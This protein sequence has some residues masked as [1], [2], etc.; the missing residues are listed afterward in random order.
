[1][2]GASDRLDLLL[3]EAGAALDESSRTV[4]KAA[5]LTVAAQTLRTRLKNRRGLFAAREG[6]ARTLENMAQIRMRFR[7]AA[8]RRKRRLRGR[9]FL[10]YLRRIWRAV[11]YWLL[12][13]LLVAALVAL[14]A[15]FW[16]SIVSAVSELLSQRVAMPPAVSSP[17]FIGPPAPPALMG[18]PRGVAP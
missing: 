3:Q 17:E 18:S 14:I 12:A 6:R 7:K 15:Y 9:I 13:L 10:L 1:M 5:E 4:A 16:S 2:Q 8:S 11:R